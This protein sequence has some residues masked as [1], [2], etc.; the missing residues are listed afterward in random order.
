MKLL[1]FCWLLAL[2]WPSTFPPSSDFEA[3]VVVNGCCFCSMQVQNMAKS[4]ASGVLVY[5]LP[6]NSLQ[7]M[8][9]VEDQ[10]NTT[11][12]IPAAMVHLEPAVAQTLRYNTIPDTR[13]CMSEELGNKS[14]RPVYFLWDLA[15]DLF[16]VTF[17]CFFFPHE[18]H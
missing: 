2:D 17:R 18:M 1:F 3:P 6:G 11:L 5:A 14:H 13:G 16:S 7:D 9:C 4:N 15:D 8:N 10:C 12:N